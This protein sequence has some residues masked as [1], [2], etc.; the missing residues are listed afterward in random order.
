MKKIVLAAAISAAAS[1]A[2]AGNPSDA[3]VEPPVIQ[4]EAESSSSGALLPLLL[5][6]L[7]AAAVAN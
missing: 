6:V 4:V 5:L 1:T 2:F 7:V 3:T